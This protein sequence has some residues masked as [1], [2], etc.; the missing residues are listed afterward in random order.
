M[1]GYLEQGRKL[2]CRALR[3]LYSRYRR[4]DGTGRHAGLKNPWPR[5]VWVR[6]PLPAPMPRGGVWPRPFSFQPRMLCSDFQY[7]LQPD[8][9]ARY[10]SRQHGDS[11]LLCL[12]LHG[13]APRDAHFSELP[14]LLRAGDLLVVNDSRV[15]PACLEARKSS[16]GRVKILLEGQQEDGSALALLRCSR[17][18]ACPARNC[19]W[20]TAPGPGRSCSG[21]T[22]ACPCLFTWAVPP[23]PWIRNATRRFTRATRARWRRP[24]PA[25]ISPGSC[26][27]NYAPPASRSLMSRCTWGSAPSSRCARRSSPPGGC[28]RNVTR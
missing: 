15:I 20:W 5:A 17:R 12:D 2:P 27:M 18:P 8:R 1:R 6:V 11:R 14:K 21:A 7:E 13:G 25:C 4:D 28:I 16:G 23:N 10:P 26:L 9:I 3:L 24:P 19:G 22:A